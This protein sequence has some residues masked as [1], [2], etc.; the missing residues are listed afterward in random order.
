MLKLVKEKL[1]SCETLAVE[2]DI[3]A[4][5]SSGESLNEIL[6]LYALKDGTTIRD[7]LSPELYRDVTE[8]LRKYGY[9]FTDWGI[10]DYGRSNYPEC[11][12]RQA[13]DKNNCLI[14]QV[15]GHYL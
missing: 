6:E 1:L 3:V 12:H 14:E 11:E 15:F 10:L 4:E 9:R 7:H 13:E 5:E 2:L 8:F